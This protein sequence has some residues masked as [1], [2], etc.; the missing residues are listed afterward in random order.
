MKN[1]KSKLNERIGP[2]L[3]KG[4]LEQVYPGAV[5]LIAQATEMLYFNAAGMAC[6]EPEKEAMRLDTLFDLASLTKVLA[7]V[8]ALM[9]L[10]TKRV[11]RLDST[12]CSLLPDLPDVCAASEETRSITVRH[13]LAHSSGLAA[14]HPFY[15]DV[16]AKRIPFGLEAKEQI[17]RMLFGLPL[18]SPPGQKS[19]YSD[20]DFIL[21]GILIEKTRGLSLEEICSAEIYK[22]LGMFKTFFGSQINRPCSCTTPQGRKIALDPPLEKGDEG[23]PLPWLKGE[24]GDCQT[25]SKSLNLPVAA[26]EFS[27]W[28][29]GVLKGEVHDENAYVMGGSAG[30]AGLFSTAEDIFLFCQ[31][32]ILSLR[33]NQGFWPRALMAEVVRRQN[34]PSGSTWALGWDTPSATGSTSGELFSPYSI[35]HT[36]FTG[37]SIWIDLAAELT[38]IFLTNRVHPSRSNERIRSFRP[39]LHNSIREIII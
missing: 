35:G 20:L 4:F 27:D 25:K 37:T 16:L 22:P 38:V 34:L 18:V 32:I 23:G 30:H 8:P 3:E 11:L 7:T 12:L 36:G 13:L 17:Y 9:H 33:D 2:L 39:L 14:W 21:L 10:L 24:S 5:L 28:R 31:N 1:S 19:L 15:Q 29:G 6:L 26:T